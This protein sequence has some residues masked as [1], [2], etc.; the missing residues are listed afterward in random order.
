MLARV[1]DAARDKNYNTFWPPVVKRL[2]T[3]ALDLFSTG[4]EQEYRVLLQYMH[5]FRTNMYYLSVYMHQIFRALHKNS[6]ND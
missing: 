1:V 4:K 2:P 3:T 5:N 6:L